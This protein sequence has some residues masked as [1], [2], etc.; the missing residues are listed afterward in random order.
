MGNLIV[1]TISYVSLTIV[2]IFST[3]INSWTPKP[4]YLHHFSCPASTSC[5]LRVINNNIKSLHFLLEK[6]KSNE[7][8]LQCSFCINNHRN[9]AEIHFKNSF[10]LFLCH[11]ARSSISAA[12]FLTDVSRS[13]S[14]KPP[15]CLLHSLP[16]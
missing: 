11:K 15:K 1:R 13:K 6:H 10:N 4:Y 3:L 8:L 16:R 12:Y 14:D 2:L 5:I 9:K 7:E